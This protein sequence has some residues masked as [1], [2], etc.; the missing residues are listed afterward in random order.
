VREKYPAYI[1]WVTFAKIQAMLRK[2]CAEYQHIKRCG[3]RAMEQRCF[4]VSPSAECGDK[5]AVRYKDRSQYLCSNL[6]GQRATPECQNLPAAPS[7]AKVA[8]AFL[9]TVAAAT[10]D[11]SPRPRKTHL[12]FGRALRSSR[13]RGFGIEQPSPSASFNRGNPDNWLVT[14]RARAALGSR[15]ARASP[16]GRGADPGHEEGPWT[17]GIPKGM[18]AKVITLKSPTARWGNPATG[19]AHRKALLR[20]LIEKVVMGRCARDTRVAR[21]DSHSISGDINNS[22]RR[23]LAAILSRWVV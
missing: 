12:Q 17:A 10:I 11:A 15:F 1:Y 13:L 7:N 2:N 20:C 23:G 16:S 18:R 4:T 21:W 9:E 3:I 22:R 19:R 6:P 5:M 14:G 8:A